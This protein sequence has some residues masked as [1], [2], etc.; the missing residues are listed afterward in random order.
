MSIKLWKSWMIFVFDAV[1]KQQ[2]YQQI[3]NKILN[4]KYWYLF[5]EQ[6]LCVILSGLLKSKIKVIWLSLYYLF[7]LGLD[8]SIC[9]EDCKNLEKSDFGKQCKKDG[10]FFKCCVRKVYKYVYIFFNYRNRSMFFLKQARQ[11]KLPRM[12]VLLHSTFVYDKN[13]NK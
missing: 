11:G 2:V 6:L 13:R 5:I 1:L 10:G 3:E 8:A 4:V 7:L 12:Q 9:Q